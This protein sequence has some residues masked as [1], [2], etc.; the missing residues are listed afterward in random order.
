MLSEHDIYIYIFTFI[1]TYTVHSNARLNSFMPSE[2]TNIIT[3]GAKPDKK[4][5]AL[6]ISIVVHCY[7]KSLLL[8]FSFIVYTKLLLALVLH[9]IPKNL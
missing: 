4:S 2:K 9:K 5:C 3:F 8:L 6:E 7:A 1:K